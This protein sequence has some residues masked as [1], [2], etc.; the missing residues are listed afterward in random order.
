MRIILVEFPWQT[1]AIINNKSSY[2]DDLIVSLDMESSY[3]LKSKQIK[4]YET[5]EFCSHSKLWSKYNEIAESSINIAKVLDE[6]LWNTD[7]RFKDLNWTF[8]NDYHYPLKIAFDQLFYYSELISILVERYKP[9]EIIVANTKKI[10][11]NDLFLIDPKISIIKHLLNSFENTSTKPKINFVSPDQNEKIKFVF[12]EKF[13]NLKFLAIKRKIKNIC[14][15][16]SFFINLYTSNHRYLSVGCFEILQ[17]KKLYPK[18]SKF[19]LSY[20]HNNSNKKKFA[21]DEIFFNKFINYLEYKTNFYQLIKH[22][23]ISFKL[24]F[25]EILLRLIKKLDFSLNEY[26]EA[27]KI[28]KKLK[29]EC[30]IFN[31]M[32]PFYSPTIAF[33]KNCNDFKIPYV[34]WA[35]G[36]YG[37]TYSLASYD[38][39]DFRFCKNHISYGSFLNDLIKSDDFI[40]KKFKFYKNYNIFSVGSPRFD[41][42][43]KNRTLKNKL[44][45]KNKPTV[46]FL[47]ALVNCKNNFYFGLNRQKYETSIWE[48]QYNILL[49]LKKYQNR[50]NIIFKDYPI[51]YN[52]LWKK[53]LKDINANKISYF[54]NEYKVN[55]LLRKSDLNILPW[56]STT[57]WEALYF[58]ADIFVIEEDIF[59]K[60]LKNKLKD[61]IFYFKNEKNFLLELEKYLEN[62]NFYTCDKTNSKNYFLKLDYLNK[63]NHLLN[64]SLSKIGQRA[65]GN[66]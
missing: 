27:K 5:Y 57:F 61:E 2:K 15:K 53:I 64:E 25:N 44:K 52:N 58:D 39:T 42:E 34:T 45:I 24:I 26:Y 48:F 46:L 59:E 6:A 37:L 17:Y 16:F 65:L 3:I 62:G 40:V 10:L 8:F 43:N 4:Y 49:L 9:S 29:P 35:H 14:Y 12:F 51:R 20:N 21:Y 56:V 1:K 19:F 38:M 60:P 63:R 50:Y 36:G 30:V 11:F 66:R 54:S 23:N 32:T 18:E 31:S 55:D 22:K 47:S 28:V 41:Y 33:R 13:V 7:E